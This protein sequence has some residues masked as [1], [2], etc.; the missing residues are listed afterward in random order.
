MVAKKVTKYVKLQI[1]AG[2]AIPAPPLGP[3][4]GQAG[5]SIG[6][7]INKFNT[8]TKEKKGMLSVKVYVYEDRSYD[9]VIKTPTT[10]SLLK[11]AA[12]IK[13]GSQ[14][15]K[16]SKVA[17]LSKEQ[18]KKITEEKMIDLTANSI[19]EAMKIIEGS[20]RSMG[21]EVK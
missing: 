1:E 19:N 11:A 4:L 6:D 9:F 15:N 14:K 2:K 21:I 10:S 13:S 17:T 3:A 16:I 20:A 5:V 12:N 8:A 18:I 7:F